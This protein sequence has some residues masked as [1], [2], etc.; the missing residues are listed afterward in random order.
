MRRAGINREPHRRTAQ[1]QR[2]LHATGDRGEG[3]FL[4]VQHIVVVQ[5]ED[6]RNPAGKVA[7][8]GL[9][10]PQR[11][12]IRVA[13][14]IDRQLEMVMRVIASRVRRK[15]SC[16]AMLES[17]IDRQNDQLACPRQFSGIQQPGNVRLRARVVALVPAHN[18][19]DP[20]AHNQ[21]PNK[22][23]SH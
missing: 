17:L 21:P 1:P 20:I 12:R 5:L 6:Q 14:G 13:A 18:F 10:E 11:R 23:R 3:I 8:A 7:G 15:A 19:L 2:I 22:P 9:D 4:I 16:R